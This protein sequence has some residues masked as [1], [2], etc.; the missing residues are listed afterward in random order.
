MMVYKKMFLLL[1]LLCVLAAIPAVPENDDR[2]PK[3]GLVGVAIAQGNPNPCACGGDNPCDDNCACTDVSCN[4]LSGSTACG[5][6]SSY[7]PCQDHTCQS[8]PH[9]CNTGSDCCDDAGG[10]DGTCSWCGEGSAGCAVAYCGACCGAGLSGRGVCEFCITYQGETCSKKTC[11]TDS[12]GCKASGCQGMICD[13][14]QNGGSRPQGC[15]S[16]GHGNPS[17]SCCWASLYGC[18]CC[19]DCR[20]GILNQCGYTEFC[21]GSCCHDSGESGACG[22]HCGLAGGI[23]CGW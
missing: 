18:T 9:S 20:D 19:L 3:S 12:A 21:T 15:K 17:A 8:G 4:C 11:K 5:V 6:C 23:G 1:M 13:W 16:C 10:G 2:V 7:R 14:C 22:H